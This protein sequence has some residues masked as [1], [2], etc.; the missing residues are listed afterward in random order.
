MRGDHVSDLEPQRLHPQIVPHEVPIDA[1]RDQLIQPRQQH[2]SPILAQ[3]E[4][5][6]RLGVD[7]LGEPLGFESI[8]QQ[9]SVLP[10]HLVEDEVGV[11]VDRGDRDVPSG[12][13]PHSTFAPSR[14]TSPILTGCCP[15]SL[16]SIALPSRTTITLTQS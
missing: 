8:L 1:E 12:S 3:A 6:S 7:H 13:D 16:N 14:I 9:P 10:P 2:P 15:N 4:S 5:L 11:G